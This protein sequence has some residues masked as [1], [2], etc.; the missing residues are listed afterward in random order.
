MTLSY[1]CLY[2]PAY[3]CLQRLSFMQISCWRNGFT[4]DGWSKNDFALHC[5]AGYRLDSGFII[6]STY[7]SR[8]LFII[9]IKYW[10]IKHKK[11]INHK[12][13]TFTLTC[14]DLIQTTKPKLR[15]LFFWSW[16]VKYF[17]LSVLSVL[18]FLQRLLAAV[19]FNPVVFIPL[20]DCTERLA[21]ER[22]GNKQRVTE[23]HATER[24]T[25]ALN[26]GP[27]NDGPL[28]K[29]HWTTAGNWTTAGHWTTGHWTTALNERPLTKG[30]W[31]TEGHWLASQWTTGHWTTGQWTT[32]HWTMGQWPTGHWTR[33]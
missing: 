28:T 6:C 9:R 24:R 1:G 16:W 29:G 20:N 18:S 17:V 12:R 11:A 21:T 2:L 33:G 23:G 26:N 14:E 31:T 27:L 3:F 13:N 25:T 19:R 30:L 5:N 8:T 10:I 15:I 7:F 22:L 4:L 32:G